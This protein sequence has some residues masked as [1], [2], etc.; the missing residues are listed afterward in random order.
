MRLT[1]QQIHIILTTIG[2][3]AGRD[4]SVVLF[5]SRIDDNRRGGDIDL[6]IDS[7]VPPNL[8]QRARIKLALEARLELPVDIIT[9]QKDKNPTPFQS[10]VLITGGVIESVGRPEY[11]TQEQTGKS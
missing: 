11:R 5:G 3:H 4:V 9:K 1:P 6:L 8:T 2:E 10:I 7:P